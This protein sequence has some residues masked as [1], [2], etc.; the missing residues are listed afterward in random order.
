MLSGFF[1]A[2]TISVLM[3][4]LDAAI[5]TGNYGTPKGFFI[6]FE[7]EAWNIVAGMVNMNL[8]SALGLAPK[9]PKF[10]INDDEQFGAGTAELASFFVPGLD[11]E[12][13][14]ARIGEEV[15]AASDVVEEGEMYGAGVVDDTAIS[16]GNEVGADAGGCGASFPQDTTIV[17]ATGEKD[18]ED[19]EVGDEVWS[20]HEK[21]G[22]LEIKVVSQTYTRLAE[23]IFALTLG[24]SVLETTAEHPL[25]VEGKGWVAAKSLVV[26]DKLSQRSGGATEV[27]QIQRKEGKVRVY[28]FSVEGNHNYFVGDGE[29]LAHNCLNAFLKR[30]N[31]WVRV[32]FFE[33]TA[34]AQD[35]ARLATQNEYMSLFENDEVVLGSY[36]GPGNAGSYDQVAQ[37]RGA[38]Y[39]YL[40]NWDAV[41]AAHGRDFM[42]QINEAFLEQQRTAGKDFIFSH[43]PLNPTGKSYPN[44]INY[45]TTFY[46]GFEPIAGGLWGTR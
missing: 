13:A 10:T 6:G 33:S 25:Y 27:T 16:G 19:I 26:G 17:T 9:V 34:T 36:D 38:T 29:W 22:E 37:N 24:D 30:V 28:N 5:S 11:E 42:W 35:Y 14:G 12:E 43:D 4:D 8:L 44:E 40:E 15:V 46:V 41:N 39:F 2:K 7:K 31:S 20:Y 32:T 3:P 23:D 45:I 18:V 21:T 1:G